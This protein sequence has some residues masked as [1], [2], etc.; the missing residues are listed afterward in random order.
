MSDTRHLEELRFRFNNGE[1]LDYIFFWG[2]EQSLCGM[3]DACLS[4][5]YESPFGVDDCRYLTAEHFMMAEKA[6]LFGDEEMRQK[7]LNAQTPAGAKA[8]GRRVRGFDEVVWCQNRFSIV[9]RANKA[10]FSQN[11][12]LRHFLIGTGSRVLVEASPADPVWGIGLG[13]EDARV[14][15]PN[16]WRGLN[17][18]GFA[19]MQV[20][21]KIA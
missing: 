15:N 8:L 2:Y 7:I 19:L 21:K 17:L 3:N 11:E 6:A 12:A 10:K 18:L 14:N 5:W 20:R 4:Q 16:E 1:K 9:M 13:Q